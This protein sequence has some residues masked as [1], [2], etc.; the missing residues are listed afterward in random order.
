MDFQQPGFY[1]Y[2]EASGPAAPGNKASLV[3]KR[4]PAVNHRCMTFFYSMYG[5]GVGALRVFIIVEDTIYEK[6]VWEKTG[7]QGK[8][9]KEAEVEISSK[10]VYR[11]SKDSFFVL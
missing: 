5:L 8:G 4:F 7:N 1:M 11:V 9:W 2:A 10:Y 6:K 3:S